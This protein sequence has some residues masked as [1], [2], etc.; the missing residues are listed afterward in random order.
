MK[1]RLVLMVDY[2]VDDSSYPDGF[3]LEEKVASDLD[4]LN[5]DSDF[6]FDQIFNGPVEP[7]ITVIPLEA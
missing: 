1:A 2:E 5:S 3:T 7:I 4:A 6:M